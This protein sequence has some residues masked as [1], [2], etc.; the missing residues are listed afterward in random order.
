MHFLSGQP[1]R[2]TKLLGTRY[3]N[4]A[5]RGAQNVFIQNR[6]VYIALSYH[7]GYSRQQALRTIHWYL[8]RELGSLFVLYLWLVLPFCQQ[9]EALLCP[10]L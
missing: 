8:P 3:V 1:V 5:Y 7:K 4:T 2:S 6:L 9:V 10:G